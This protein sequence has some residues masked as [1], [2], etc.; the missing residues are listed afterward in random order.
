MGPA[1][2]VGAVIPGPWLGQALCALAQGGAASAD[3]RPRLPHGEVEALHAGRVALPAT[4]GPQEPP[5]RHRALLDSVTP[6]VTPSGMP[7]GARPALT[8]GTTRWAI[9]GVRGPPR[10]ARSRLRCGARAVQTP[11]GERDRRRMASSGR[12]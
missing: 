8:C 3:R 6:S 11:C 5:W 10:M 9:A 12:P 7:P 1:D 4:G 2:M